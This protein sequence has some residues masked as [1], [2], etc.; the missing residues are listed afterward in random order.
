MLLTHY[1]PPSAEDLNELKKSL[2]Y[3]GEQMAN[4]A[5]VASASQWRKY[6]S[7]VNPRAISPHI[8]FFIAAQ[9]TLNKTTLDTIVSKMKEVGATIND[10][11]SQG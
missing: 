7:G 8:L 10:N 5:G 4:L 6:T 11:E 1:I 3:T 2:G 9:L